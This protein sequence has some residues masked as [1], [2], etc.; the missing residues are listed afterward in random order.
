[1]RRCRVAKLCA[2]SVI[3]KNIDELLI[4][5]R[6]MLCRYRDIFGRPGEGAHRYRIGPLAA[7]DVAL[8]VTGVLVFSW[9]MGWSWLETALALLLVILIAVII[10]RMFC[11]N[12]ALNVWLLGRV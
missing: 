6:P 4:V 2:G 1:M 8:T 7:V 11:V 9:A 5:A 12:T 3:V 10:H